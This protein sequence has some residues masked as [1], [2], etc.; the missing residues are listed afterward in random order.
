[1]SW[2]TARWTRPVLIGAVLA[3]QTAVIAGAW[4][5][6][7]RDIVSG[8]ARDSAARVEV[9]SEGTALGIALAIV[10]AEIASL[11]RGSADWTRAQE[12][13][14]SLG[15]PDGVSVALV[16]DDGRVLCDPAMSPL[17][18]F[19][20]SGRVLAGAAV[21][22]SAPIPG[23]DAAVVIHEPARPGLGA[24]RAE[25]TA[26]VQTAIAGVVILTLTGIGAAA[27]ISIHGRRLERQNRLLTERMTEQSAQVLRIREAMI[28]GLAKLAD[29]RDSDTGRHL[30]RICSYVVLLAE[31]LRDRFA[32]IDDEYIRDLR[33][34]ASLHDIGKVGVP[35]AVLLK[36]GRLTE[37]EMAVIR[38]HPGIGAATLEAIRDRVGAD[39]PL[40]SMSID[41]ALRHHERWDGSGYPGGLVRDETPLS[42]RLLAVADVYDALTS[43]RVYK[44]AMPHDDAVR[45]IRDS[46]G[47][48][49][50]PAVVEAFVAVADRFDGVRR[51][52]QQPT[53]ASDCPRHL[54]AAAAA[55]VA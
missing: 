19:D 33:L 31:A 37:D 53:D 47:S 3:A 40:L 4:L 49:L 23:L 32:E 27:L 51:V 14:A 13:L 25:T 17:P 46:S 42:A 50:D 35:D 18:G 1:M 9:A 10:K 38:M 2:L 34:A 7:L 12:L 26:A 44:D 54:G 21:T 39:D 52:L 22:A 5:L 24:D 55:S 30:D 11:E 36:R 45:I 16:G 48:H 43:A 20:A 8:V 6:G 29:Y 41:I 15:L 28:L